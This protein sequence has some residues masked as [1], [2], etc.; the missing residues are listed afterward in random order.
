MDIIKAI[1]S[2]LLTNS[3]NP[4]LDKIGIDKFIFL[5]L[6]S[7]L[8]SIIISFLY[9]K[10]YKNR[11]TGSQIHRAFPLL[12]ISITAIFICIQFSLPLSL[13]LLGALSIVRFR[14]PIKEPE[15][16]G[17][18]ML[19]IASSIACAT[20]SL[21]FLVILLAVATAGLLL[22]NYV[23]G[24]LKNLLNDGIIVIKLSK[25]EYYRHFENI[26]AALNKLFKSGK[27]E[28]V[29]NQDTTVILTYSFV[30]FKNDNILMVQNR[31]EI[32]TDKAEINIFFNRIGDV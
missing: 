22:L 19:L 28:S 18:L 11:S 29:I 7:L 21:I 8:S 27:I 30:Q 13:G 25:E 10:F 31:L 32:I 16:I 4:E 12:G 14:T 1:I 9:L 26:L 20:F 2:R 24:F 6:I 23:F 17:F 15:E 5:L 3:T